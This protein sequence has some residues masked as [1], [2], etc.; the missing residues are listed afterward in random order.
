[1]KREIMGQRL[2]EA[3]SAL[4][5]ERTIA[6]LV[7]KYRVFPQHYPQGYRPDGRQN[8]TQEELENI[9]LI[10]LEI[11]GKAAVSALLECVRTA[12]T[13]GELGEGVDTVRKTTTHFLSSTLSKEYIQKMEAQFPDFR[14]TYGV[15]ERPGEYRPINDKWREFKPIIEAMLKDPKDLGPDDTR[16]LQD[17]LAAMPED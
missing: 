1:M 15:P 5:N 10:I 13:H 9:R 11:G 3:L 4:G 17:A 14:E 16:L 8:T 7:E 6:L 2:S 12:E